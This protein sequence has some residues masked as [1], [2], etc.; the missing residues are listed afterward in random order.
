MQY[1]KRM[2]C[3]LNAIK[4]YPISLKKNAIL[5]MDKNGSQLNNNMSK[6]KK[7]CNNCHRLPLP[8]CY[9]NILNRAM[10]FFRKPSQTKQSHAQQATPWFPS[11][12]HPMLLALPRR[13]VD[14]S[15]NSVKVICP[16]PLS[17]NSKRLNKSWYSSS[18]LHGSDE[19]WEQ[20]PQLN[21]MKQ[22]TMFF[23]GSN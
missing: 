5:L 15:M 19:F 8:W 16:S 7:C 3:A 12:T 2:Q 23:K 9:Q 18:N 4:Y 17:M 14:P 13:R 1:G 21:T 20:N 10:T 11:A 22:H 6:T